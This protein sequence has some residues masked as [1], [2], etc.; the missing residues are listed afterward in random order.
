MQNRFR[1][2][3][4]GGGF[5][6]TC[7]IVPGR[8]ARE[9]SQE[10]V[11]AEAVRLFET[12]Q[13]DAVSITDNPG[14]NPALLSDALGCEFLSR[15]VN[16]LVHFTCKDRNRNQMLSQLYALSRAGVENLL[17]MTGDYPMGGWE[18]R[19][20]PVFDLDSVQAQLL[21]RQMN[22]GLEVEGRKGPSVEKPTDFFPGC[23]VTPYKYRAG[24]VVPQ[25]LKLE[26]KLLAGARFVVT[27]LGYD[28][29]KLHELLLYLDERGFDVP[30]IANVYLL[31][32][33]SA[34]AMRAGSV[35]G[36]H[37]SDALM[38][39]LEEEAAGAD[40]GR[41]MRVERAAQM[42]AI[43]RGLGCAGVH[44]GGFGLTA[45]VLVKVLERAEE[46][47]PSWRELV[48]E[49]SFGEEGGAYLYE[50]ELDSAGRPT[51]LNSR[52]HA[53][54][55]ED[56]SEREKEIFK[57]YRLSRFAH[58]WL[59]TEGKGFNSSLG[60]SMDKRDR[61]KG[62]HRAHGLEH[63]SKT[64]IYGCRDCGDC[65][66]DATLYSCPMSACPKC[67]RNG[68]CGGSS[69][70]WC[71]VFPH[72]RLC[73]WYKAYHRAMRYGELWR[74]TSFITPPNRWEHL[75]TSPWSNYTHKRDN[76]AARIPVSLGFG[77]GK[78][79]LPEGEAPAAGKDGG[80]GRDPGG[81]GAGEGRD[82]FERKREEGTC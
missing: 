77:G 22:G 37:V 40:K 18:G 63:L 69:E 79:G 35:A 55:S 15:G 11:V 3:V 25:Y 58:S 7:E 67:Q 45:E 56:V 16:P 41:G 71:E 80:P 52:E 5:A 29:R 70:G 31:P 27:Q 44:I 2:K 66:L 64:A 57:N 75:W 59:F 65:G 82:R 1:E 4:E 34:R 36:C 21:V 30:V 23:V 81:Q 20:R 12:G 14:G 39:R 19:S 9:D 13:V 32:R 61:K 10:A 26:K 49:V 73:I 33:G 46:L 47:A 50:P 38:E 72:E 48:G 68:P 53:E 60:K 17:V 76:I 78:A 54:L 74:M 42:V 6:V 24:E 43:A 8:G 28:T 62:A 51:G